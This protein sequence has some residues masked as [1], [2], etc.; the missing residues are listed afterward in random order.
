MR[1]LKR[2]L[3]PDT[4]Q[5]E[6]RKIKGSAGR[7]VYL[8]L[9]AFFGVALGNYLWGDH[10][11]LR[12]DGLVLRD[13]NVVASTSIVQIENI[14]VRR[15][16]AVSSGD[17]LLKV[18]SIDVLERI[19]EYSTRYTDLKERHAALL[20]RKK[21]LIELLPLSKVRL[22]RTSLKTKEL[23][24]LHKRKLVSAERLEDATSALHT[25]K[26][27]YT[28]QSAELNGLELEITATGYAL[29]Q[30]YKVLS[31]L[32]THYA[33]GIIRASRNGRVGEDVPSNGAV[34]RPGDPIMSVI[35][36]EAYVL[37]YL[38]I[39]YLFDV[40]EG[41]RVTVKSG[42]FEAEGYIAEI[43]PVSQ[44]VPQEFQHAF[45][46]DHARQLARIEFDNAPPF[47]TSASVKITLPFFK[48]KIPTVTTVETNN[49]SIVK[50]SS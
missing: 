2:R 16:Q 43:L 1:N 36:G 28:R 33:S 27:D 24:D 8:A 39:S 9:L 34:Y 21:Q 41:T 10:L 15:G 40:T 7:W 4:L 11:I 37:A 17:V 13:R 18:G 31:D 29:K 12:A 20:S 44:V 3:R 42:R 32:E 30:S 49:T 47:P 23:K 19:A 14:N 48:K 25:A 22:M 46:P 50:K 45:R 5:N 38:P 26:V 6:P 35:S